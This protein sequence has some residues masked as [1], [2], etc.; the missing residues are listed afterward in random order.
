MGEFEPG[1]GQGDLPLPD[2]KGQHLI[3]TQ[4]SVGL[5]AKLKQLP[6]NHTQRPAKTERWGRNV[7]VSMLRTHRNTLYK[8]QLMKDLKNNGC[9]CDAARA[10]ACEK[11]QHFACRMFFV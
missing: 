10:A 9:F 11:R 4:V 1:L 3:V 2:H 8:D 7:L 6:Y 5:G